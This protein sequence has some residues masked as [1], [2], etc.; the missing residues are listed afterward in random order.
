MLMRAA[1]VVQVLQDLF[2]CM[3]YFTCNRSLNSRDDVKDVG[4]WNRC[5]DLALADTCPALKSPGAQRRRREVA[6]LIAL[7]AA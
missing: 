2:Y 3:F 4:P 7:P 5:R 6:M 1:T